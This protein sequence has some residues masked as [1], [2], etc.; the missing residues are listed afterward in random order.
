MHKLPILS[1]QN[2]NLW[3]VNHNKEEKDTHILKDISLQIDAG[4]THALVGESGSGKSLTALAVLRLI[5]EISQVRI[6]GTIEFNRDGHQPGLDLLKCKM[7]KIRNIRGNDIAMIFQ[8]PMSALNPV[9]TIGNQLC[10]PLLIHRYLNKEE[11]W[12]E[13]VS[14]LERCGVQDA[15]Y[16]MNSYP[17]QLSGGQRQRVTIAMALACRPKLLIADEPTTALDATTQQQIIELIED[18][19][20]E[21]KMTMLLISHD[22]PMV[23]CVADEISIMHQGKIVE[24]GV[25]RD[26]FQQPQKQYTKEL[27]K[28]LPSTVKQVNR[29]NSPIIKLENINCLFTIYQGQKMFGKKKRILKALDDVSLTVHRG[30]TMGIIGES[31]SGKSTLAFCLLKLISF[32]G[33]VIYRSET[34]EDI[35]LTQI[36]RKELRILRKKLQIIFQ[37]PYSSLSPRLS[38]QQ[39]V[40]EGLKV[41]KIGTKKEREKMVAKALAEVE[42]EPEMKNRYPHEFS[43]GQ[44]QR[45]AIARAIVLKPDVL[46]LDEPTSALDLTVQAQ[47]LRLLEKLQKNHQLTY[48]FISHDLRVIRAM[49]DE[50]TIMKKGK[51]IESGWA[52]QV[53]A[54]PQKDY[55]KQLLTSLKS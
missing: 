31:G 16:R 24:Q 27:L 18:I 53:L 12:Q 43:G 4:T 37:D 55:S 21:Y 39:I 23:E 50:L 41:H 10:E 26:I 54:N 48:I 40:E 44:R 5:E 2:L 7:K 45:I 1:I 33:D 36:S 22:L 13:G 8:E 49:S 15:E 29:S 32:S 25:S 20:Q 35:S 3:F 42:L 19:Q 9:Y 34:G 17:H 28:A 6:S 38:I 51:V 46:V 14:L 47:I 30:T 52:D 11:A